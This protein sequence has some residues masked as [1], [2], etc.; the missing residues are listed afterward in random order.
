MEPHEIVNQVLTAFKGIPDKLSRFTGKTAELFRSH[1]REPKSR[2]PASSGNTSPVTNYM[3][4]IHQ[5]EAAE[6]GAGKMLNNRVHASLDAEFSADD[7]LTPQ[8]DLHIQ[9]EDETCDVRKW[10][11]KFRI[12]DA[13]EKNLAAFELEC[14]EA[15]DALNDA[16]AKARA[17]RRV[18]QSERRSNVRSMA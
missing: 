12:S 1:G 16:K 5:Y 6:R 4:Y 2:N 8:S 14:D 11:T 18:R 10:L 17:T 9:V 7:M 3:E 13:S 15:I